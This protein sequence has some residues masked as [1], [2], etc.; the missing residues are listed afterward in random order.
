[1]LSQSLAVASREIYPFFANRNLLQ[2]A[3]SPE[4]IMSD[5]YNELS[6]DYKTAITSYQTMIERL[7]LANK[8]YAKE[9]DNSIDTFYDYIR[10]IMK[11]HKLEEY[12]KLSNLNKYKALKNLYR[13][14]VPN[15]IFTFIELHK[16]VLPKSIIDKVLPII[17]NT[18]YVHNS[19]LLNL[20]IKKLSIMKLL[21][22]NSKDKNLILGYY[23]YSRF[24]YMYIIMQDNKLEPIAY[25]PNSGSLYFTISYLNKHKKEQIFEDIR[26]INKSL[27]PINIDE[28]KLYIN[29]PIGEILQVRKLFDKRC[30]RYH[31]KQDIIDNLSHKTPNIVRKII[32]DL[33]NKF[34]RKTYKYSYNEMLGFL[35]KNNII[36]EDYCE[37]VGNDGMSFR[38]PIKNND[39]WKVMTCTE[40]RK[41]SINDIDISKLLQAYND[42]INPILKVISSVKIL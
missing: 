9:I 41:L 34:S 14:T 7:E 11:N 21:T 1:M 8:E 25:N 32:H 22:M 16:H 33:I 4:T 28:V 17:T 2:W 15:Y 20:Y 30:K 36:V 27:A 35:L 3:K 42:I 12:D 26:N 37:K 18:T 6:I 13:V 40:V 24:M 23:N 38:V 5:I 29:T 31:T 19:K 39:E 10:D